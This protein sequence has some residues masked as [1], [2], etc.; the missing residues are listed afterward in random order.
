AD[1]PVRGAFGHADAQTTDSSCAG[2]W[3]QTLSHF[4]LSRAIVPPTGTPTPRTNSAIARTAMCRRCAREPRFPKAQRAGSL[5][6]LGR[7]W[8]R[9]VAGISR[10]AIPAPTHLHT[11][12]RGD[13]SQPKDAQMTN[14]LVAS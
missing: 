14:S 2:R 5:R 10:P 9:P 13:R 3:R 6:A 4:G 11:P 8:L 12:G 1:L 7:A